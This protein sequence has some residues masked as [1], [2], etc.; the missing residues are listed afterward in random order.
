MGTER[1]FVVSAI[2]VAAFF[3][4]AWLTHR[5]T[6]PSSW[7]YLLDHP[8]ERSLHA[9]PTPRMGGVAILATCYLCAGAALMYL[10]SGSAALLWLGF[11]GLVVGGISFIDDR[12]GVA[13]AYRLGAHTAAAAMVVLGGL[14]FSRIELPGAVFGVQPFVGALAS[15]LFIVWMINLYNFMDGM[16]G[17]AGGM[18]MFG[19]GTLA[20]LGWRAEHETFA[21]L[22]GV[23]AASGAGFLAFNFPPARIFMGDVGSSTLGLFAGAFTLWGARD[24]VFPLWVGVLVFSPFVADATVTL[25]RRFVRGEKVWQ[26]H[27]SHYY[28]RLVQLGWGH[29]KTVLWEYVLMGAC[30]VSAA[31]ALSIPVHLQWIMISFWIALYALLVFF[32]NW[33]ERRHGLEPS[34]KR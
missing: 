15:G 7:L 1:L 30:A 11:A 22:S 12:A 10:G 18:A 27:K 23:T 25:A 9:R 32:V 33:L 5:F 20:I 26:A 34:P 4:S 16:D 29:R 28:Q 8:N 6:R 24:G 2:A 21:L 14:A 3:I 19:F 31:W 13:A 17:F